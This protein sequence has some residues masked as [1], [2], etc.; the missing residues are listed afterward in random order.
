MIANI[1]NLF[2]LKNAPVL[3]GPTLGI[4]VGS[5]FG[6][7]IR[8]SMKSLALMRN[9]AAG[10][11]LAAVSTELAPKIADVDEW[12]SRIGVLAGIVIGLGMMITLR[13]IFS[14][15]SKGMTIE[16]I[17]SIAIDFFI[18]SLLIG[19]ALGSIS[20]NASF[21]MAAALGIE[22]FLLS[23]TT[24]SQLQE[25]NSSAFYIVIVTAVFVLSSI[26][27][28]MSGIFVANRFKGTPAF[29]TLLAFGVAALVWLV[30]EDLLDKSK[31]VDTRLGATMLFIGFTL[32]VVMGWF[33]HH[34]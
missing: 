12:K 13:T 28:I 20:S 33:G 31:H 30:T 32:V 8:P 19:I 4:L 24:M 29:Y 17:I 21:V 10:L 7:A 18:D 11:V 23:M 3:V 1:K 25:A 16:V 6:T 22:M 27:G 14:Q 9:V 5:V 2:T 15:K 34:H 26:G